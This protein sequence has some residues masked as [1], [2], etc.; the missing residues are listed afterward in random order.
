MLQL[1]VLWPVAGIRDFDTKL[2]TSFGPVERFGSCGTSPSFSKKDDSDRSLVIA[3]LDGGYN[4]TLSFCFLVLNSR[5]GTLLSNQVAFSRR[6]YSR[7]LNG[8]QITNDI[9]ARQL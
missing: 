8:L 4:L 6:V 1:S 3:T 5:C 7:L 2:A 9:P